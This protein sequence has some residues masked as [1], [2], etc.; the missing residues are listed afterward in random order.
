[1]VDIQKVSPD[2]F[3]SFPNT[4]LTTFGASST[5]RLHLVFFPPSVDIFLL[6]K[7]Q[8]KNENSDLQKISKL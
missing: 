1:M 3:L 4:V 6:K 2:W 7:Q 8:Y 5:L